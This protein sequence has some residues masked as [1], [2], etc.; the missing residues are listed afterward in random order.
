MTRI[1]L[2]TIITLFTAATLYCTA[3][4]LDD[5]AHHQDY[6]AG[7][8]SSYD[9]AGGNWDMRG[10]DPGQTLTIADL[11]GPGCITHIWFTWMYPSRTA[12]RK[13]VI[14][15]YFDG[16]ETPCIESP[17]G[18]FFGLGHAQTYSYASQALAVGTYGGLNSFW[19]MP[20]NKSA[21]ITLT[22]D[23]GQRCNAIYF[24]TD[25]QKYDKP[26][27][28]IACFHAQYRQT[29]PCVKGQPYT[30]CEAKGRGHFVGCNLSVEQL[31]D[32]WWG[33]GDDK[34]FVDGETTPSLWGTGSE[35][36]FLGAWCFGTEFSYPF[37]GVP[38][39]GRPDGKGNIDRYYPEIRDDATK[40]WSWPQAWLKGDLWNCYRYHIEDP[41]PFTTSLRMDMEHGA[42]NNER[43]DAYSSVAYWYQDEPHG[44]QPPLPPVKDRIPMFL[45]PQERAPG[46]YEAE[47][48]ADDCK[49][50]AGRVNEADQGFWGKLYSGHAGLEWNAEHDN[51]VLT[52]PLTIKNPGLYRLALTVVGTRSGGT[53][54]LS[55]NGK[56]SK[57]GLFEAGIFP[58]M[59]KWQLEPMHLDAGPLDL[60]FR[61]TG[62]D[63]KS[64][65]RQ[66]MIDKIE[67]TS[68]TA[69]GKAKRKG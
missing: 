56:T 40:K 12:L 5:L 3:A 38:F 35:D 57:M 68:G 2:F 62:K 67:M 11:K 8:E 45:R 25:Y 41:V 59:K 14:R 58:A 49:V 24:Q 31:G 7:R 44:P 42:T 23:G 37:F 4:T 17:L 47:D 22:N 36:Y 16:A 52:V 21:R 66:L 63:A 34:F 48:L 19:R 61:S 1:R 10:I 43:E 9:R 18:D 15:A 50:S 13:L 26:Q 32:G 51:D 20:F 27:E 28:N 46:L 54:E 30:I 29:M 65:G 53:F 39:R 69:V 64:G 60:V 55:A 6:R 33:E